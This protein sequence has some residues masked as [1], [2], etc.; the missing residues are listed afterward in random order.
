MSGV[1]GPRVVFAA[2]LYS[3]GTYVSSG[4]VALPRCM[5]CG[6]YRQMPVAYVYMSAI[7]L[8]TEKRFADDHAWVSHCMYY[9]IVVEVVL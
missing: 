3:V 1:I 6:W 2:W 8:T 4:Q 7:L 9:S 5:P